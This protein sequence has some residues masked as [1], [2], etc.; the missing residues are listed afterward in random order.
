MFTLN[1]QPTTNN[2]L[3]GLLAF[4]VLVAEAA[5]AADSP[6]VLAPGWEPLHFAAPVPGSYELPALGQAGDGPVLDSNGE[7]HRLYEFLG[8]KIA[9]LSFVYTRCPD[10]NACPMANYVLGGIQKRILADPSTRDRARL[11]TMSFDPQHDRPEV[12][13]RFGSHLARDG[14]DWRFL[15]AD[16]E[17][18]LAPLLQAYGQSIRTERDESGKPLGTISHVLRV[19]LIDR[20]RRIR[21]IYSSAFLH[22]DTVYADILTVLAD[23]PPGRGLDPAGGGPALHGSGDVKDGY[24]RADYATRSKSLV[25]RSGRAADLYAV[26]AD[27]PLGLPRVPVP[28]DNPVTRAKVA[29]GRRLFYDRRLSRNDTMSCA[30]CHIPEQGF[31]SNEMATALGIEGQTVRRNA[32]TLYNVAYAVSFFDDGRESKLERQIWGPLL[33]ANE[34]GNPSPGHVLDEIARLPDYAGTFE[35]AFDGHGPTMET[36]GMALASY[37]RTLLS[38][39]SPFDRSYFGKEKGAISEAAERGFQLFRGK[40]RC[41]SCHQIEESYAL[42]TDQ[43][44]HNTGVGYRQTM[45]RPP[46]RQRVQVA[47]GT[48][49]EI[50]PAVV[51]AASE[52]PPSDLGRYEI[53]G[54]PED[55]WKYKTPTLRNVALTAPY[56]HDGSMRTLR[57]V[58]EFYDAGGVANEGLD[59]KIKPL[60]LQ[61]REMDDLV[62]FLRSL[63]GDDVD[64]IVADAFAAPVGDPD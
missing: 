31:T 3:L 30:M 5:S 56:M 35:A 20:E 18:S 47:P 39:A 34:M 43:Q 6:V 55:R 14:M 51:A 24:E 63:T 36:L 4:L 61:D 1:Q 10:V 64:E 15:T 9:V 26:Y 50:D 21:N 11:I 16:S 42:F 44:F 17:E 52:T 7:P 49:L 29:L 23:A 40:A 27:P 13:R 28:A 38:A 22:A 2:L 25:A 54:R 53:T 19:Y 45:R 60:G 41:T 32:P 46:P 62:A 57:E 37:E 33:A 58:V 12:M 59:P 48:F 8:D